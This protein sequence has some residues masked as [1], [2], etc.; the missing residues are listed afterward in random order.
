MKNIYYILGLILLLSSCIK[1]DNPLKGK[2]LN[3]DFTSPYT[4]TFSDSLLTE[5]SVGL[6]DSLPYY[7]KDDSIFIQGCFNPEPIKISYKITGDTLYTYSNKNDFHYEIKYYKTISSNYFEDIRL[8]LGLDI[9]LP[10]GYSNLLGTNQIGNSIYF[11]NQETE[12]DQHKIYLN[13]EQVILDSL[14]HEKLFS[15][16]VQDEFI[17][18][19]LVALNIDSRIEYNAVKLLKDELRKA[20]FYKVAFIR[21][22]SKE[23]YYE[24]NV[25]IQLKLPPIFD[26]ENYFI[27]SDIRKMVDSK[28]PPKP[29]KDFFEEPDYNEPNICKIEII[30]NHVYLNDE[31]YNSDLFYEK[32]K[33]NSLL[34]TYISI[35]KLSNY[36]TYFYF[37]SEFDS[38]S[39]ENRNEKSIEFFQKEYNELIDVESIKH[40]NSITIRRMIEK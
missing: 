27:N 35:D 26:N 29:P 32:I 8:H 38:L 3:S 23:K 14:L 31:K 17:H 15:L 5:N 4:I 24:S 19:K 10:E 25:G 22:P 34:I 9:S 28:R 20:G 13:N 37:I 21:D 39:K 1:N 6:I 2:W 33:E 18:H 40:I 30:N 12:I 11:P 36:Q 7:V 16:R